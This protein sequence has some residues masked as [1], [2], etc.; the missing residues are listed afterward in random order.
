MEENLQVFLDFDGTVVS[1]HDRFYKIYRD[2]Y[3]SIG[4]VPLSKKEWKEAR[5]YGELKYPIGVREKINPFFEKYFECSEYLLKYDKIFPGMKNVIKCLQNKYP[6]KIV[7][8]RANNETLKE[9]L[10]Y[11]GINNVETIIQGFS[12]GIPADEKANMIQRVIP[13]PKGWIIGDCHYEILAGQ[14]LGLKTI[15]VTWGDQSAETLQ[16]HNPDFII[17]SPREILKIIQ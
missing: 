11:L 2:A 7:S 8:F 12:P 17:D 3:L 9:Q 10:K 15:A 14:K 5:K 1:F 4:E 13:N 16:R 6:I